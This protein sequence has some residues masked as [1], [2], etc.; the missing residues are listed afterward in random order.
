M[1]QITFDPQELQV[2]E[3]A[4]EGH[5]SL[6]N[7]NAAYDQQIQ[8]VVRA[9]NSR[10]YLNVY[11]GFEIAITN[12]GQAALIQYHQA[13]KE[14]SKREA[15]EKRKERKQDIRSNIAIFVSVAA[16]IVSIIALFRE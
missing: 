12:A 15:E 8:D 11:G 13:E 5:G 9:L 1:V 10:G 2:M 7:V 4:F 3:K 16:L 14:R 6:V